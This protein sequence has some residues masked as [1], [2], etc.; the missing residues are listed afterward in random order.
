M[1][2]KVSILRVIGLTN[3]NFFTLTLAPTHFLF[4]PFWSDT[5]KIVTG[6]QPPERGRGFELNHLLKD[7]WVEFYRFQ[8]LS[9]M[10]K[11]YTSKYIRP[12][13]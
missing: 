3:D 6:S 12:F 4:F 1:I 10:L 7:R 5:F 13:S 2:Y 8:N 9:I 11:I